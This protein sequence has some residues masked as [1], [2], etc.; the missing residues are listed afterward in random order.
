MTVVEL[1]E[2]TALPDELKIAPDKPGYAFNVVGVY[3]DP[4]TQSWAVPMCRLVRQLAEEERVQNRWYDVNS[5][6]D[7][8]ILLE[9]VHAALVADVIVVSVYAAD[10]LPLDLY[11]WIDAWLPR[12]PSRMGALTA[13][14][15]V[16]DPLD[17]Q[18]VRT[19][20]YLEAVA[21]KAQLDFIPQERKR[22]AAPFFFH[23][24]EPWTTR[25]L[26]S[27]SPSL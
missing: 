1:Q 11:V 10:E 3:Q 23:E 7:T 13:L 15:G 8:R 19:Q 25:P 22:P 2:R 26:Q 27:S 4:L 12:R 17:S 24:A 9:A 6:S 21:R 18:S 14:I 5:L 20:E 16:A